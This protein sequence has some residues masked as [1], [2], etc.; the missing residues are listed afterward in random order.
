MAGPYYWVGGTGN[1]SDATNHWSTSSGG[2]PNVA[3]SPTSTD[4]VHFDSLSNATAYTVTVDA[5]ATCA[6]L[7]FD[8][9]PA[10]SGTVTLAGTLGSLNVYGNLSLLSGMSF[11]YASDM[12]MRGGAGTRTIT[13]NGVT[14]TSCP[15]SILATGGGII[16]LADNYTSGRSASAMSLSSGTFDPNG[17]TVTLSGSQVSISGAFTFY[18]LT[19]TGPSITTASF[20]IDSN[21]TVTNLFTATGNSATNRLLIQSSVLGT[22][23]TITCGLP[24]VLSNVDCMD[25]TAAG[26]GGTWSGAPGTNIVTNG[27][28]SVD[29]NWIKGTNWTISGGTAN[30]GATG[31]SALRQTEALI[32]G[33]YY[34]VTYTVNSV[35]VVGNGI[36]ASLGDGGNAGTARTTTGTFSETLQAGSSDSYLW[37]YAGGAGAWQ[38]SLTNITVQPLSPLG[39]CLGN[40]GITF[41]PAAT[42][43]WKTTTTGTKTWSTA[44]NWFLATNGGG[45]A[46]RVPLPQD[47]VVFD[48]S[49]IGATGTTV[50]ADIPR[51]GASIDLTGMTNSPTLLWGSGGSAVSIF[52]SLTLVSGMTF[53]P[54]TYY[55]A[56]CG[57][58]SYTLTTAG[59]T[60]YGLQVNAPGG[61]YTFQDAYV[62]TYYAGA[63]S[64]TIT[65]NFNV[66]CPKFF[67][68]TG[69]GVLNMGSGTWTLTAAATGDYSWAAGS[70]TFTIN[71]Q[72]STIKLTDA[73]SGAKLFQGG[74][75]TYNNVWFAGGGSGAFQITGSNTFNDLR[76]DRPANV[77]LTAGTT[78]T[79]SS[80]TVPAYVGD[81]KYGVL[82]GVSGAYFSTA[83][84]AANQI[85]GDACYVARV[86]M[87]SWT[88]TSDTCAISKWADTGNQRSFLFGLTGTS[89]YVYFQRSTTGLDQYPTNYYNS[90]VATGFSAGSTHW[91][92]AV[93]QQNVSGSSNCTFYTSSDGIAW[94]QLGTIKTGTDTG[95]TFNGTASVE[96]GTDTG[97]GITGPAA[98]HYRAKL[99]NS[100]VL[101]AVPAFDFN[102]NDYTSGNT[103][104][105]STTG[106]TWT[107]NGSALIYPEVKISSITN[108]THTLNIA[109]NLSTGIASGAELVSN[110]AFTTDI[111]GWAA[112]G[113]GVIANVAG[114]L[115]LT[116]TPTVLG[117][118]YTTITT[119][120]GQWYKLTGTANSVTAASVIF[121][122]GTSAG[123][124]NNGQVYSFTTGS[125]VT[126]FTVFQATATTTY[127]S[128]LEQAITGGISNFDNISCKLFLTSVNFSDYLNL[129]YSTVTPSSK[130]YAGTHSLDGGNN[131]G[132]AFSAPTATI[133]NPITFTVGASSK[134]VNVTTTGTV[135]FFQLEN[136]PFASSGI[137]NAGAAGTTVTRAI[138][139]LSYT[140][141]NYLG[142]SNQTIYLEWTPLSPF[143]SF[144]V[145]LFGSYVD[146]NNSTTI[147]YDGFN[148]NFCNKIA[149]VTHTAIKALNVTA[150]TVYKIAARHNSTTGLDVF[151][152]GVVGVND[153][154]VTALQLGTTF[155]IG[156]DGNGGN[157]A[158]GSIRFLNSYQRALSN[159]ELVAPV[160]FLTGTS[161]WTPY[162]PATGTL[163]PIVVNSGKMVV[164][165]LGPYAG[166]SIALTCVVGQTYFVSM[167]LAAASASGNI[168]LYVSSVVNA[169]GGVVSTVN[170]GQA[171]GTYTTSFVATA[172]TM[173][174]TCQGSSSFFINNYYSVDNI[175]VKL[176]QPDRS[177]KNNGLVVVGTLTKSAV[178]SGSQLVAYSGFSS[179]NYLYQPYNSQL[180][181]GTG[182]FCIMGWCLNNNASDSALRR[183][184]QRSVLG[185]ADNWTVYKNSTNYLVFYITDGTNS[186]TATSSIV[187]PSGTYFNW[188]AIKRGTSTIEIWINNIQVASVSCSSVGTISLTSAITCIGQGVNSTQT[189]DGSISLLRISAT[190]PTADQIAYIYRTELPLFQPNAQCTLDGTITAVTALAYDEVA[191]LLHVGTSWGR[192]TFR[193]LTRV[194]SAASSV[195]A[196]TSIAANQGAF[197]TAGA[198]SATYY[199]PALLL[200]D[201]LRRK[202]EAQKV[203]GKVPVFFDYD[204][205]TSQ[206]A[207]VLPKGYTTKAVY[208]AN[209][210]KRLGSTKDYTTSFDGFQETVTYNTAPGNT[211]WVT[212]MA[213]RSN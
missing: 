57:R 191:D 130:W 138:D 115:Q 156:T 189:W 65:T 82:P 174:V 209:V 110:S 194:S 121:Y 100:A 101:T 178:A 112:G 23:R 185:G 165:A 177:V 132:W 51:I 94:S 168:F 142:T 103:W 12:V 180:D 125:D 150:N 183:I 10:T 198:T 24:P 127:I 20:S 167:Q 153:P 95:A 36:K 171:A 83:N 102:P 48:A 28:F 164:T 159:T 126:L 4:N 18:N 1:W 88:P 27:S 161:G 157:S 116:C 175:S 200:R 203:L 184:I 137:Q 111:S 14:L 190:A 97:N 38:G 98:N 166:A 50:V 96:V 140:T 89:G 169:A 134:P 53:T 204:A 21:I 67:T 201:E 148:I 31:G 47:N 30:A 210:L 108:A 206:V 42:Q 107:R 122:A 6:D 45:G 182:D 141:S 80:L 151:I 160:T 93:F 15:L 145:Y 29:A 90:G 113:S 19:R 105:S 211:V 37:L 62:G 195:G 187:I 43:Y 34:L 146:S 196:I 63:N 69:T 207:F 170:M 84:A 176:A 86:T 120:I 124:Q 77:Q 81:A 192:I 119:V 135:S 72:T 205:V 143:I 193:D 41:T 3:N 68:Q 49:S 9:A 181:F 25:I 54:G 179:S 91:I 149:G 40:S 32:P 56:L 59:K 16:Q 87:S 128:V 163:T 155:Q 133:G 212:I 154:T 129:S 172:T 44:G 60:F 64:G 118:A 33:A 106:E 46:G 78:T 11:T 76:I 152:N 55:T 75:K 70:G 186:A 35:A 109:P 197:I 202:E 144:P 22:P 188:A 73:S 114:R 208:S 136:E 13:S 147:F 58:S 26:V 5:M 199:Q 66:T 8:A 173:Y 85:T 7:M 92:A 61:T 17:K 104:T 79:V 2:S 99:I 131:T 117:Y 123:S 39:N 213:I 139:V 52:G 162:S 74:G 158:W 71:A